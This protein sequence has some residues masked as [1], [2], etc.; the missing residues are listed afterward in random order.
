MHPVPPETTAA[1]GDV[2]VGEAALEVG[3]AGTVGEATLEVGAGEVGETTVG[4]SAFVTSLKFFGLSEQSVGL[5]LLRE[6]CDTSIV[7]GGVPL[8]YVKMLFMQEN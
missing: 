6:S 8:P 2:T 5:T 7:G 1:V 3:E 4:R